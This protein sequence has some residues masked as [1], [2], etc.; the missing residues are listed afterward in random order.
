MFTSGGV[1]CGEASLVDSAGR[2]RELYKKTGPD[3][4]DSSVLHKMRRGAEANICATLNHGEGIVYSGTFVTK[5]AQNLHHCFHLRRS[6]SWNETYGRPGEHL[7]ETLAKDPMRSMHRKRIKCPISMSVQLFLRIGYFSKSPI[8]CLR[9]TQIIWRVGSNSK[10]KFQHWHATGNFQRSLRRLT[11]HNKRERWA[12]WNTGR[13]G[14]A[15]RKHRKG[16]GTTK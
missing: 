11:C 4:A 7:S 12:D 8:Y 10:G 5:H 1:Y 13:A 3:V 6:T 16:A 2:R 15:S 9:W 14:S